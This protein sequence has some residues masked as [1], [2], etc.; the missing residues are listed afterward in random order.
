MVVSGADLVVI[1]RPQGH[2]LVTFV[3]D[4]RLAEGND[5]VSP[6]SHLGHPLCIEVLHDLRG[7]LNYVIARTELSTVVLAPAVNIA[8]LG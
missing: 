7:R 6:A 1:A 5:K 2:C 8:L 4:Q 3:R